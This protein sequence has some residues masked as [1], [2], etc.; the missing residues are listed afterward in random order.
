M[1]KLMFMIN[2]LYGGG[3]EKVL[4]TLLKNIDYKKYD[5]T[6]Y[7]MHREE[8]D[9]TKY[10]SQIHYKV[11][12]DEHKGIFSKFF[13]KV[14][15]KIFIKCSSR[16]FYSLFIREKYDVEIAF[17]EGESTKIIAG[18][19]NK[20]SK[21][22]AWVHIDLNNNPWTDFLY[23][24]V[25]DERKHYQQFDK[26][27]CVSDSVKEAFIKKYELNEGKVSTQY[28]PIDREEILTKSRE[29]CLLPP[30]TKLRMLAVGRLV[31]QKGFDRLVRIVNQL[32]KKGFDFELYILGEGEMRAKLEE[33]IATHG[34][35]DT[36]YL[37]GFQQNPYSYMASSDLIVCSS[38][39][40]GFST[41]V[42]EAVVLG[43]P[44]VSTDCAGVRELFGSYECGTIT[45]N[46]EEALYRALLYVLR[47]LDCLK[48]Y[49][50]EAKVRGQYFSL[51]NTMTDL[52]KIFSM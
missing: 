12:F 36:V 37:L 20:K 22:L 30:K 5:V 44:I 3:A 27:L 26:I 28:N 21:K 7:S 45:E 48:L 19:T 8:L 16:L 47:N 29:I 31:E 1:K 46:N 38:R 14:K 50:D 32:K 13:S 41:V 33:Y 34:L 10:P 6:L 40:E 18:S 42:S 39:S 15:G 52:E 25:Q 2:S 24:D 9:F 43:I 23:R 51:I 35:K 11:V 4:Q 17:I 49:G